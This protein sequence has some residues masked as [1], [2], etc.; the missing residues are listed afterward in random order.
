MHLFCFERR[1]FG[2]AVA[3]WSEFNLYTNFK[4]ASKELL[5]VLKHC[6]LLYSNLSNCMVWWNDHSS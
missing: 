2:V 4:S 3:I 5:I 1:M 6:P